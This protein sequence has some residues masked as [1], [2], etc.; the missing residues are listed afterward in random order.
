MDEEEEE[1]VAVAVAVAEAAAAAAALL[2][3]LL[4]L[5]FPAPQYFYVQYIRTD[6]VDIHEYCG[7]LNRIVHRAQLTTGRSLTTP[8]LIITLQKLLSRNRLYVLGREWCAV[9]DFFVIR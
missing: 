3:L 9:S 7:G 2:L 8:G 5:L 6:L 4:L 1:V